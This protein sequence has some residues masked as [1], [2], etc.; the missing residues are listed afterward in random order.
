MKKQPILKD[1]V[2]SENKLRF[3][4][5]NTGFWLPV[6]VEFLIFVTAFFSLRET[7]NFLY[8]DDDL[9]SSLYKGLYFFDGVT[10]K[11]FFQ[12]LL[13]Q[14]AQT[15]SLGRINFGAFLT[16]I[17]ML[18]FNVMQYRIYVL[19]LICVNIWLFGKCIYQWT[20]S[21]KIKWFSM[22]LAPLFF[23]IHYNFH[24]PILSYWGGMQQFFI[25][26]FSSM[27]FFWKYCSEHKK[28]WLV[29]SGFLY[30]WG[31]VFY[32]VAY[33]FILVFILLAYFESKDIKKSA[34][35]SLA[36]IA[37]FG[38][39]ITATLINKTG[40]VQ[41][42]YSGSSINL[43]ILV[44]T[45]A[46]IKQM[47][48]TIPLSNFM[49]NNLAQTKSFIPKLFLIS[50]ITL[51]D[52]LT[53]ILFLIALYL[54][55]RT[56]ETKCKIDKKNTVILGV[57]GF[58]M[59]ALPSGLIGI[60]ARYQNEIRWGAGHIPVY[61]QYFGLIILLV[62]VYI[63]IREDIKK[64]DTKKIVVRSFNSVMVVLSVFILLTNQQYG[65][66]Q[67]ENYDNAMYNNMLALQ[68]SLQDNT[69]KDIPQDA[70]IINTQVVPTFL[71]NSDYSSEFFIN[72]SQKRLDNVVYVDDFLDEIISDYKAQGIVSGTIDYPTTKPTY[73]VRTNRDPIKGVIYIGRVQYMAIN[74]D[75]RKITR[76]EIDELRIYTMNTVRSKFMS[77]YEQR[78]GQTYVNSYYEL[79]PNLFD[80]G[81]RGKNYRLDFNDSV[82]DFNTVF[83]VNDI[84]NIEPGFYNVVKTPRKINLA[85][86]VIVGNN[87]GIIGFFESG[88]NALESWGRWTDGE[89]AVLDMKLSAVPDS[90]LLVTF[91]AN[92]FAPKGDLKFSVSVNDAPVGDFSLPT[93]R[94]TISISVPKDNV[95]GNNDELKIVFDIKNPLSPAQAG[96]SVDVRTIGI[97]LVSFMVEAR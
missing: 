12:F 41:N 97:G 55:Y 45:M 36:H 94:Q 91:E 2:A 10:V 58:M 6:F 93:G 49:V 77:L 43:N 16:N 64:F 71:S 81:T 52:I 5:G 1:N 7:L 63:L 11:N 86:P 26:L 50:S 72:Y 47:V 96:V 46:T 40:V 3:D 27:Y 65:R 95:I 54:I 66:A 87:R 23:Q 33:V 68:Y 34:L 42:S 74:L 9:V 29:I 22:L 83:L 13:Q 62:A 53:V 14:L 37:L 69:I 19:I 39:L 84:D 18:F 90:D 56:T 67:M 75:N 88:W 30:L 73:I 38:I 28:R 44:T 89:R 31:L 82:V 59:V 4:L 35:R 17:P 21:Y 78:D 85:I 76:C 25:V 15:M 24:H 79:A 32:E 8:A 20:G 92:I 51:D 80:I 61:I 57:L 60:S 48:A 70:L